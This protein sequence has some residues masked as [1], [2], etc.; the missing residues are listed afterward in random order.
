MQLGYLKPFSFQIEPRP[1][2][3]LSGPTVTGVRQGVTEIRLSDGRLI[4]AQLHV[5]SVKADPA[6]PGN[7][8]L[9][10]NGRGESHGRARPASFTTSTRPFSSSP[11]FVRK[12]AALIQGA[13]APVGYFP[14]PAEHPIA[15]RL[16][17]MFPVRS[18][19]FFFSAEATHFMNDRS[20]SSGSGKT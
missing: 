20:Q 14:L 10:Y 19:A 2:P 8:E 11:P 5:T 3:K 12:T 1:E 7:V 17:A 4:R 18:L 13:W 15:R 16:P 6:K 9:S